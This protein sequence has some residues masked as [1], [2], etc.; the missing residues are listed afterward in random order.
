MIPEPLRELTYVGYQS[1]KRKP[2]PTA[3]ARA[4]RRRAEGPVARSVRAWCVDRD[5]TCR[6][7]KDIFEACLVA[8]ECRGP[9]EW[10][11]LEN[12]RRSRTRGLA[13]E[14]RHTTA[15]TAMLCRS[16]HRAYDAGRLRIRFIT[17]TGADG[18]IQWATE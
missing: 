3:K 16:H 6:Y 18:L 15:G 12:Q 17:G 11:H 10:A 14:L 13:P 4:K 2:G 9:S 1:R 8:V 7:W 5:G